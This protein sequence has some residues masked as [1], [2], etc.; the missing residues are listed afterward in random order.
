MLL[1]AC[2]VPALIF[3]AV[4][5]G[6]IPPQAGVLLGLM[7]LCP[8]LHLLMMKYI[9]DNVSTPVATG[10]RQSGQTGVNH[11]GGEDRSSG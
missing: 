4:V 7:L 3:A 6:Y 10:T 2:L 11:R 9:S 1:A 5:T 8:L